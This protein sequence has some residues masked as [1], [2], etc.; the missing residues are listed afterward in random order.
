M[1]DPKDPK[2][3]PQPAKPASPSTSTSTVAGD[4]DARGGDVDKGYA[5]K[6]GQK[7]GSTNER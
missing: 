2:R 7:G 6:P 3:E 5:D 1:A 4:G